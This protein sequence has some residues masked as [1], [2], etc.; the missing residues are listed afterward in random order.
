MKIFPV[1]NC[2]NA[3]IVTGANLMCSPK[4]CVNIF[5]LS[6]VENIVIVFQDIIVMLDAK[7]VEEQEVRWAQISWSSIR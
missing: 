6:G 5:T 7:E 4:L 2:R 1:G 3:F